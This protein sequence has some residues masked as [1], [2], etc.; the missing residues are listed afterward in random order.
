MPGSK[1][2]YLENALLNH[3]LGGASAGQAY[4]A[5]ANVFIALYTVAPGETGGGTE[6][7][8]SG[9]G[10]ARVQLANTTASFA[11]TSTSTKTNA[12]AITFP[13]ATADWGTVVAFGIFDANSAG[14]LL[15]YG[16]LTTS[17]AINNGDTASFA[18]GA[19][20]ITED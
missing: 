5:P 14:N 17:K 2:D 11:A 13:T 7:S 18:S 3:T 15:Y 4:S 16:T 1:S 9:T 6:V 19:I 8:T 20:T 12:A 10:Y